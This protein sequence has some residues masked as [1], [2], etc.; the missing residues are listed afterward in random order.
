[1]DISV[2][3]KWNR[4]TVRDQ[5]TE[6]EQQIGQPP[7]YSISDNDSKLCKSIREQGDTQI[8]DIG[9]TMAML[10][11]QV[12]GKDEDYLLYSKHLSEVKI[13]E[14]MRPGS[15]NNYIR[16]IQNNLTHQGTRVERVKLSLCNYLKEEKEKLLTSK[17][18][19]HCSSDI[20]ESLFGF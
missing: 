5:L 11:E 4:V 17:N 19:W 14:V 12:Y 8:R 15:I 6:I 9:H 3:E 20:I 18:V 16:E 2:A 10:I 13:R 1:M 7:L